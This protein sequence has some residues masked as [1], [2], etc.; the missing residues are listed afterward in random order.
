MVFLLPGS[1]AA[2]AR[3]SE[4]T[5]VGFGFCINIISRKAFP[6]HLTSSTSPHM[7]LQGKPPPA[8]S[9]SP[10]MRPWDLWSRV[11]AN[12]V[13]VQYLGPSCLAFFLKHISDHVFLFFK[14]FQTPGLGKVGFHALNLATLQC[15]F[16]TWPS[17]LSLGFQTFWLM[18][19]I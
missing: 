3:P 10:P 11:A 8:S 13:G 12:C 4:R 2:A 1:S 14:S 6:L 15:Y 17:L 18:L 16:L 7:S 19:Y 9:H 5:P